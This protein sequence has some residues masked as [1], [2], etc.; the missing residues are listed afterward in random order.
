MIALQQVGLTVGGRRLLSGVDLRLAEGDVAVVTGPSGSGK[1]TLL[2]L[3][4]G[5]Y[6]GFVGTVDVGSARLCAGTLAQIRRSVAYVGQEPV[7]GAETVREA[8]LLPFQFKAHRAEA[9]TEARVGEMLERLRL[10]VSVLDQSASRVSGGEKQRLVIARALLLGK[11]IFL[12]DEF[13]S[14]LDPESREAAMD[15]LGA[16]GHTV[17]S[18]T[19]DPAWM[20]RCSCHFRMEE[21]V[22]RVLESS[23]T[24][25]GGQ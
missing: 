6:A 23:A 2:K 13:T 12:A 4:V 15:T 25:G 16:P 18:V 3:I 11:R 17:L 24:S 22:L 8:L 7:L 14:A 9:P 20:A 5:G 10:R 1:S 19:H 21:G